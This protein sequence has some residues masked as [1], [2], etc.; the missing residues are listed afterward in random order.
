MLSDSKGLF[1]LAF[2]VSNLY[3]LLLK[4][5]DYFMC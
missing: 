4:I 1:S 3:I 2:S 5:L